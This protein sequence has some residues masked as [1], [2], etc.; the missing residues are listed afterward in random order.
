MMVFDGL[1]NTEFTKE[2]AARSDGSSLFQT[3][4]AKLKAGHNS[5]H[6]Q[7]EDEF[8]DKSTAELQKALKSHETLLRSGTLFN[9]E[10]IRGGAAK[11]MSEL[12]RRMQSKAWL[13]KVGTHLKGYP[14]HCFEKSDGIAYICRWTVFD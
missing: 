10:K 5:T 12:E 9:P 8:R 13:A 1:C 3:F 11:L 14:S 4:D 7:L 2:A 6:V